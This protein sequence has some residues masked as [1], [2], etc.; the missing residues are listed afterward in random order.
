[1]TEDATTEK[2]ATPTVIDETADVESTVVEA[3]KSENAI[4]PKPDL[5]QSNIPNAPPKPINNQT[6]TTPVVTNELKEPAAQPATEN[7]VKTAAELQTTTVENTDPPVVEPQTTPAKLIALQTQLENSELQVGQL[8]ESNALLKIRL[9]EVQNELKALKEQIE[10]D[11]ETNKEVLNYIE[12]QKKLD[13]EANAASNSWTEQLMASP[14]LLGSLAVIPALGVIGL[15]AYLI[16]RRPEEEAVPFEQQ[17]EDLSL[18]MP[19]EAPTDQ[20]SAPQAT[21]DVEQSDHV[22]IE[23]LLKDE[24]LFAPPPVGNVDEKSSVAAQVPDLE[25]VEALLA[26]EAATSTEQDE[27]T[28]KNEL[29]ELDKM[30]GLDDLGI[31]DEKRSDVEPISEQAIG[32]DDMERAIEQLDSTKEAEE[33]MSP[34]DKLAEMWEQSLNAGTDP[35]DDIDELLD[36]NAVASS[37]DPL[38]PP[39]PMTSPNGD[40]NVQT[41]VDAN[42]NEP[43]LEPIDL[44]ALDDLDGPM[45]DVLAAENSDEPPVKKEEMSLVAAFEQI[46]SA[47]NA[48]KLYIEPEL[49]LTQSAK[50][51]DLDSSEN[52]TKLPNIDQNEMQDALDLSKIPEYTEAD[53]AQDFYNDG[54]SVP[55]LNPE[56]EESQTSTMEQPLDLTALNAFDENDALEAVLSE[57]VEDL[58]PSQGSESTLSSKAQANVQSLDVSETSGLDM[59]VLLNDQ[60]DIAIPED[61]SDIWSAKQKPAPSLASED[62]SEQP[63]MDK[64]EIRLLDLDEDLDHLLAEADSELVESSQQKDFGIDIENLIQDEAPAVASQNFDESMMMNDF[65]S[66]GNRTL[67]PMD[68][69]SKEAASNLDL[70]KAYIEMNDLDGANMLLN[71]VLRSSNSALKQEAQVLLDSIR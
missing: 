23:D 18:V 68:N 40:T 14:L 4:S 48:G 27:N 49:D 1:M 34:D 15:G 38:M 51:D 35:A 66:G 29:P 30:Q 3:P 54:V 46:Q 11:N 32:L 69:A 28:S 71:R 12:T 37:E 58:S 59:D 55:S 39:Q 16:G 13:A 53:A 50:L 20:S 19:V 60:E 6:I 10:A 63:D 42:S 44:E 57:P 33:A 8:M 67:Q 43:K 7:A 70:A 25:D 26:A 41:S 36:L 5:S 64:P 62:W 52:V 65:S 21:P 17:A 31:T 24:D 47:E 61:E 2:S 22:D 45:G 9:S 56:R